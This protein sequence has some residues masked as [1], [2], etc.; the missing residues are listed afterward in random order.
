[1][2]HVDTSRRF[3]DAMLERAFQVV[4]SFLLPRAA[5]FEMLC[6]PDR[7]GAAA[8]VAQVRAHAQRCE[9][10]DRTRLRL[11]GTTGE[12]LLPILAQGPLPDEAVG[13]IAPCQEL[14]LYRADGIE[15]F[16]VY[17]YGTYQILN[18]G[19][20]EARELEARLAQERLPGELLSRR[21]ADELQGGWF[22][23]GRL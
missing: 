13:D 6:E 1:M 9:P 23:L 12:W 20:E 17:D 19:E 16:A 11:S 15:L 18:L 4:L 21:S 5:R 7:Q 10:V 14:R 8:V 3:S 2:I 22:F